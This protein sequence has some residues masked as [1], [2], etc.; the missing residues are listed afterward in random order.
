MVLDT[1]N[2]ERRYADFPAST[3]Q[4]GVGFL[5]QTLVGEEWR[6][7]L[8]REDNMLVNLCARLR[9]VQAFCETLSG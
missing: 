7:I 6:S 5:T 2:N 1:T 3:G 9:H 4:V 8:R